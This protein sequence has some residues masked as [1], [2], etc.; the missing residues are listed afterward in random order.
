LPCRLPNTSYSRFKAEKD[1]AELA[2]I[3]SKQSLAFAHDF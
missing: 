2:G 3:A 1:A